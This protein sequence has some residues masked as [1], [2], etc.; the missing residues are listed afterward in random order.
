MKRHNLFFL[1]LT[2]L[3]ASSPSRRVLPPTCPRKIRKAKTMVRFISIFHP[4]CVFFFISFVH[5]PLKVPLKDCSVHDDLFL[6]FKPCGRNIFWTFLVDGNTFWNNVFILIWHFLFYSRF[7]GTTHLGKLAN[8]SDYNKSLNW[9]VEQ[10]QNDIKD[11][12]DTQVITGRLDCW[13]SLKALMSTWCWQLCDFFSL[14]F[15]FLFC[16]PRVQS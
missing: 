5:F 2:D 16:F 4:L 14:F 11:I 7:V 10:N 9:K 13:I 1:L 8:L 3:Q 15:E 12:D 6:K